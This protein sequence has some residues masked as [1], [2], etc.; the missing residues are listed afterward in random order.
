MQWMKDNLCSPNGLRLSRTPARQVDL[1]GAAVFV[2]VVESWRI[3]SENI[4][5]AWILEVLQR[6]RE[7]EERARAERGREAREAAEQA[8]AAGLLATAAW[9]S[10]RRDPPALRAEPALP[11]PVAPPPVAPPTFGVAA[12]VAEHRGLWTQ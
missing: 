1:S 11:P 4:R 7:A 8:A 9:R 2:Q 10:A 3:R 6:R 5:E 12:P